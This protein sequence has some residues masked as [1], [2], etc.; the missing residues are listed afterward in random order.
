MESLTNF[1]A[2]PSSPKEASTEALSGLF[3]EAA[4]SIPFMHSDT[5]AKR[6]K[7]RHDQLRISYV[8]KLISK[9]QKTNYTL[10][11]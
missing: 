3:D 10:T 5:T 4:A 11:L 9:C 6:R 2:D 7:K 8:R 1:L